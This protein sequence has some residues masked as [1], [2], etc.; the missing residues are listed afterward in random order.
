MNFLIPLKWNAICQ[1]WEAVSRAPTRFSMKSLLHRQH[2]LF[3]FALQFTI[4]QAGIAA[5]TLTLMQG[6]KEKEKKKKTQRDCT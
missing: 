3:L 2:Q 4:S 1:L 5:R 6:S